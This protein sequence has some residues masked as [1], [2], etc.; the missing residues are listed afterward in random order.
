MRA[1]K[2]LGILTGGAVQAFVDALLSTNSRLAGTSKE[3]LESLLVQEKWKRLVRQELS[4]STLKPW[5][6][7][8]IESLLN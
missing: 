8:R 2:D 3:V 6:R 4:R 1:F 7:K 5:Q